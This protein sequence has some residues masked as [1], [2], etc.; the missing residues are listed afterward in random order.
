[1][2]RIKAEN[3]STYEEDIQISNVM[4]LLAEEDDDLTEVDEAANFDK[5]TYEVLSA[6][7]LDSTTILPNHLRWEI[8][9]NLSVNY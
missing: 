7:L 6:D 9:N 8:P 4:E 2:A 1:M 5:S 3:S